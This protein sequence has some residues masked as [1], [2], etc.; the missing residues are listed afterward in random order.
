MKL[1][2]A[3]VLGDSLLPRSTEVWL[4]EECGCALGRAYKANGGQQVHISDQAI[5]DM[6]PWLETDNVDL[7]SK[8][9]VEVCKG[10]RTFESLIDYVHS[11]EPDFSEA[12]LIEEQVEAFA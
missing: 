9:F 11:V 10:T 12:P 2:D 3:M 4:D 6:W 7:I 8:M 1:I 5:V